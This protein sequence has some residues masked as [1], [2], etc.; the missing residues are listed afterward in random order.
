MNA[1]KKSREIWRVI[2]LKINNANCSGI[3]TFTI[4]GLYILFPTFH[5]R[6]T[7][8]TINVHSTTT[9]YNRCTLNNNIL[10]SMYTQQQYSTINVHSTTTFYNLCTL[11]NN[12]LQSVYTQQQYST[13]DVHSTTI[14]YNLSFFL[15]SLILNTTNTVLRFQ[16]HAIH[17]RNNDSVIKLSYR[18]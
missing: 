5:L 15:L 2:R 12:V 16:Q 3:S 10:Q 14:F 1:K 7:R 13:I 9:F 11:N 18:L 8:S 17:M 6:R 4:R